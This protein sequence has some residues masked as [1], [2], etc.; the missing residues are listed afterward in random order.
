MI[1]HERFIKRA[2]A[3][4]RRM[5]II[6]GSTGAKVTYSK[7]LIATFLFADYFKNFD[8]DFIGLMIPT[9]AG[10]YLAKMGVLACGKV[11]VMINYSTGADHNCMYAQKMCGFRTIVTSKTLCEKIGCP[12]VD[13]MVYLEDIAKKFNQVLKVKAMIR[14]KLPLKIILNQLP[15]T[16]IE[17]TACILFTSGSESEPKAVQLT[18]KNIGSNVEDII[19]ALELTHEDKVLNSLPVFHVFGLTTGYWMPLLYNCVITYANPLEF[20]SVVQLIKNENPTLIPSTPS[21]LAGYLRQ[22]EPGD[23]TSVRLMVPGGDKTPEWLR[24][25]YRDKHQIELMEGY[26][27]TETSPVIS[28]NTPMANK[29]GSVGKAVPHA[30]IRIVDVNSGKE[31]M[32]G[33]EGKILVKGDLVMKGYFDDLESTSLRIRDG[34]YD[35]G[36]MGYLDEEGF[37]WHSGRLKRFTKIGGEM[38]SM[39]RTERALEKTLPDDV[40]CCVVEIPD[41][42]K[43]ARIIAVVTSELNKEEIIKLLNQE[44]PA[45]AVPKIFEI[46]PEMPKMGNGKIDFRT[47]TNLVK[48]KYLSHLKEAALENGAPAEE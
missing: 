47:V 9:S 33:Q 32:T 2:K 20:K 40:E 11:P 42:R 29:P 22:S 34:W 1:L 5:A 30:R 23:F 27:T 14:S 35:T 26:G 18:H 3:D 8:D 28:V 48:D 43:G 17:D 16:N 6:D 13:G 10:G 7:A 36:D 25:A 38:I 44:L 37:L 46:I 12:D 15:A 45:I 21:F 24:T 19:E 31:L 4:R 41:T 39:V